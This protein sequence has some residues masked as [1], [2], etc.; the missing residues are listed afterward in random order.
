VSFTGSFPSGG[1]FTLTQS[2]STAGGCSYSIAPGSSTAPGSSGT[3][4]V[5]V[6]G[7]PIGC[8][9]SWSSSASSAGGWLSLTGATGGS[10][11]GSV[12]VP[13][14]FASN[15]S[16]TSTRVGTISFSGSL[17]ATFTLTQDVAV[18]GGGSELIADGGFESATASGGVGHNAVTGNEPLADH[19][20]RA[21]CAWGRDLRLSRRRELNAV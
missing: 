21:I 8:T 7:S 9:G 18:G 1:I 12:Q 20:K 10:S 4:S 6:T 14:S 13:Y 19:Q 15:P 11:A 17:S 16:T 2:P 3:G 5:Q